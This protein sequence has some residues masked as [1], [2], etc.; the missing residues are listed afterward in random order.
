VSGRLVPGILLSLLMVMSVS[1][2]W[3]GRYVDGGGWQKVEFD[4][5]QLDIE[6][7]RGP[8][9]GKVAVSYEFCIPDTGEC[10]AEVGAIDGSVQ[11]MSG[12]RGRIGAVAGECLCIGSTHQK[13]YRRVLEDLAGLPYVVR[14]IECHFE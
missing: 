7:L 6:G 14:I 8:V 5:S 3:P 1:C 11:F 12:S 2:V 13:D 9:D 10:R 4:L